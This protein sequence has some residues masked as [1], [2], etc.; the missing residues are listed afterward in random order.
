MDTGLNFDAFCDYL[1]NCLTR[2]KSYSKAEVVMMGDMN[3]NYLDK[4]C[5]K[6]IQFKTWARLTG[7]A[8]FRDKNYPE[9]GKLF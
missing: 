1:D 9:R 2:I 7:L 8:Q 6:S 3:V 5:P 4:S